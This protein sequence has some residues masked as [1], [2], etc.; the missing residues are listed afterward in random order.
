MGAEPLCVTVKTTPV[1]PLENE[2][3]RERG[4]DVDSAREERQPPG[5]ARAPPRPILWAR[6]RLTEDA[7]HM[8]EGQF[9]QQQPPQGRGQQT[10]RR[11]PGDT[12]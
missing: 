1:G 3:W 7:Q 2:K 8:P 10:A 12:D 4:S 9:L 5:V 6:Q 11:S